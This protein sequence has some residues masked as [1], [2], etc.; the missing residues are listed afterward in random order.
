LAIVDLWAQDNQ[1]GKG[2]HAKLLGVQFMKDGDAF[3]AG[4]VIADDDFEDL[5]IDSDDLLI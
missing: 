1:Y 2:I 5:G 4:A 3:S